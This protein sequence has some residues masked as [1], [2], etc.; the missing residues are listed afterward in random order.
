MV[1]H[2]V[3]VCHVAAIGGSSVDSYRDDLEALVSV[4]MLKCFSCTVKL[5]NGRGG[6]R[7]LVRWRAGLRRRL[8][9]S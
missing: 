8:V 3:T 1:L 4:M 2:E 7:R 9:L 5:C 6:R